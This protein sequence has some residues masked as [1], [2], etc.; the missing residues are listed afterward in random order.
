ML[1][2][3]VFAIS[4]K[5]LLHQLRLAT[6]SFCFYNGRKELFWKVDCCG[7]EF[8]VMQARS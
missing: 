2:F 4:P 6:E 3:T 8:S 5:P 7:A 1:S